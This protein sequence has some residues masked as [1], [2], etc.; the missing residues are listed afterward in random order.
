MERIKEDLSHAFRN[1]PPGTL[2]GLD[3][4]CDY[5]FWLH[6]MRRA[7][8]EVSE[9]ALRTRFLDICKAA[10][11]RLAFLAGSGEYT[12]FNMRY[13]ITQLVEQCEESHAYGRKLE[14]H[15][16]RLQQQLEGAEAELVAVQ[17][18]HAQALAAAQQQARA[19]LGPGGK[20]ATCLDIAGDGTIAAAF[21]SLIAEVESAPELPP[22]AAVAG[23]A[24]AVGGAPPPF[25]APPPPAASASSSVTVTVAAHPASTS[26]TSAG[27]PGPA[28]TAGNSGSSYSGGGDPGLLLRF[29]PMIDTPTLSGDLDGSPPHINGLDAPLALHHIP[30]HILANV[31]GNGALAP[32]TAAAAG[33][34]NGAAPRQL[35]FQSNLLGMGGGM[36]GPAAVAPGLSEMRLRL[37][38]VAARPGGLSMAPPGVGLGGTSL[39][40]CLVAGGAS[41]GQKRPRLSVSWA[42]EQQQQPL[43]GV[44]L[45]GAR[46]QP[47]GWE[48]WLQGLAQ[49]QPQLPLQL[50][51]QAP[52]L[53]PH[54]AL[55]AAGMDGRGPSPGPSRSGGTETGGMGFGA[56]GADG[57]SDG[58]QG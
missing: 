56:D 32:A 48:P 44:G 22:P 5:V 1:L 4:M 58:M 18:Q 26:L 19:P 24:A 23:T 50:P 11:S 2:A 14:R 16:A 36:G 37:E 45:D 28:A 42:A 17:A 41:A 55:T 51:L 43:L 39:G 9:D 46:P 34:S 6:A 57:D 31:N 38:A 40:G 13:L 27:L 25:M 21:A 35:P 47:Q 8:V 49:P 3:G 52:Q 7:E 53:I 54:Q 10:S 33:L 12:S 30:N 29:Q 15:M 20:D